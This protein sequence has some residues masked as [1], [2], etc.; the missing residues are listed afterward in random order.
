MA[1]FAH[2]LTD[3]SVSFKESAKP[4]QIYGDIVKLKPTKIRKAHDFYEWV[5]KVFNENE[6][7]SLIESK[8]SLPRAGRLEGGYITASGLL[9]INA[10]IDAGRL[11]KYIQNK[12]KEDR[13]FSFNEIIDAYKRYTK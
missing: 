3:A 5:D 13:L 4:Y 2:A 1:Q 11:S 10:I 9:S 7:P 8:L 6:Q 12:I